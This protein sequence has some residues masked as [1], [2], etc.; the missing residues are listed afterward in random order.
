M[1]CKNVVDK[2]VPITLLYSVRFFMMTRYH[3]TKIL[4]DFL[5][6]Q[7]LNHRF[8]IQLSEILSV[9]ITETHNQ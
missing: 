2:F 8:L 4:I 6:K 5:C 9:E 1:V 7:R 3:Q